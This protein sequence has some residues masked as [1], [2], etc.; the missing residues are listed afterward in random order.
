MTRRT[1]LRILPFAVLALLGACRVV[2]DAAPTEVPLAAAATGAP[3]SLRTV[4]VAVPHVAN[5]EKYVVNKNA[6]IELGKALFWDQATG[7]DGLACASCH[8]HAG[9]DNRVKSQLNP[10]K[11]KRFSRTA[12]GGAGGPN[13]RMKRA[14]F[15]FNK[16]NDDVM[17]SQGVYPGSFSGTHKDDDQTDVCERWPSPTFHVRGIGVREVEPRNTPTTINAALNYRNFWDGRANNSFNGVDPFGLRSGQA[18]VLT[19]SGNVERV[20]LRNSSLAS[21]GVGPATSNVEMICE[22]RSPSLA[23]R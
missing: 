13:Y 17:S 15:P 12:R 9:A 22:G 21:Q 14:D 20:D 23:K 6:T 8:F 3:A 18:N 5:L 19:S 1:S 11:N 16:N 7:S 2:N 10:G 4:S